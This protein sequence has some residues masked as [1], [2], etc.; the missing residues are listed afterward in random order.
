MLMIKL[1]NDIR[2]GSIYCNQI[3]S[4][5][6]EPSRTVAVGARAHRRSRSWVNKWSDTTAKVEQ[7]PLTASKLRRCCYPAQ[8]PPS[9]GSRRPAHEIA[10]RSPS[11]TRGWGVTLYRFGG[12]PLFEFGLWVIPLWVSADPYE[13]RLPMVP[14]FRIRFGFGGLLGS[15]FS[16]IGS[17]FVGCR[18]GFPSLDVYSF[19]RWIMSWSE[20]GSGRTLVRD[21]TLGK[22]L[23][24]TTITTARCAPDTIFLSGSDFL[25]QLLNYVT[26]DEY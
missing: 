21:S 8:S 5:R 18:F 11:S 16:R 6:T 2:F 23:G 15:C 1:I 9:T 25:S 12:I 20:E 10:L 26:I 3:R 24:K 4:T 19:G 7:S 17:A 13:I 22:E 14:I